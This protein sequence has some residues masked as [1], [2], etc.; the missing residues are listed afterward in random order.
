V[1]AKELYIVDGIGERDEMCEA[2]L[3]VSF[4]T[5]SLTLTSP[6]CEGADLRARISMLEIFEGKARRVD[7][8]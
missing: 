6:C 5:N 3:V 7:R 4:S 8:I 2:H 1:V